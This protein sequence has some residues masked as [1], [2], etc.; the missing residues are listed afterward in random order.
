MIWLKDLARSLL[1]SMRSTSVSSSTHIR[2]YQRG[3]PPCTTPEFFA[4]SRSL[5]LVFLKYALFFLLQKS[6]KFSINADFPAYYFCKFGYTSTEHWFLS[7]SVN[8]KL[9]FFVELTFKSKW[10]MISFIR[11]PK[12]R[13]GNS[14]LRDTPATS[15]N[16]G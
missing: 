12:R 9:T 1:L 6:P 8:D 5:L 2:R 10:S 4:F 14:L 15:L 13:M 11:L 7:P 3:R 16:P